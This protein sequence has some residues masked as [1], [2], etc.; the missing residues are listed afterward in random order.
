MASS[1]FTRKWTPSNLQII[2]LS[3]LEIHQVGFVISSSLMVSL[4]LR[5][6]PSEARSSSQ[7]T[8]LLETNLTEFQKF[9]DDKFYY[10]FNHASNNIFF[11]TTF[12][13]V[14]SSDICYSDPSCRQRD[15]CTVSVDSA[16][17][18]LHSQ[19]R[20]VLDK[21]PVDNM[22]RVRRTMLEHNRTVEHYL[23]SPS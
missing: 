6:R 10:V 18:L 17:D 12:I 14:D 11:T 15:S 9:F 1:G 21:I 3:F 13:S 23:W 8:V 5:S 20:T 4:K 7:A 22:E 2:P 16:Y 19:P